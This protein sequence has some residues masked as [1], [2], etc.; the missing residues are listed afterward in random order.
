MTRYRNRL[1]QKAL[2]FYVIFM[3]GKRN[4]KPAETTIFKAKKHRF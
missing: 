4:K 3:F 1:T 2:S